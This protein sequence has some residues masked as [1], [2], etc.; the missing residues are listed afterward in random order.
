MRKYTTTALVLG[1]AALVGACKDSTVVNPTD[2]PTAEALTGQPLSR[3]GL[4]TLAT[5][6]LAAD[7]NVYV[8][9]GSTYPIIANIWA[10]EEVRLDAS[11][12]RY[13]NET[14][15]G[16]PDYG[17]F[18]GG[19]GWLGQYTAVR[20]ENTMLQAL[21]NPLPDAFSDA[22]IAA[23]KGFARTWKGIDYYRVVELRDTVGMALQKDDPNDLVPAPLLCKSS[24]LNYVAALLDSANT[25]L[26][27]ASTGT[28]KISAFPWAV[29]SGMKGFGR[30]Y[31]QISNFIKFNRGWKGKVDLYRA[32]N[33]PAPA[34]GTKSA[35]LTASIAELTAALGG[36]APG[37]VSSASFT[38][39]LYHVFG[40]ELLRR[41]APR[42]QP[43]R[44]GQ[45]P[46]RR[47]ALE[48]VRGPLDADGAGDHPQ[49]AVQGN[50]LRLDQPVAADR[51]PA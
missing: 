19:G 43:E 31:S 9:T 45:A 22:E 13:V 41:L 32:L 39:G 25:E 42:A 37:A 21:D 30:D 5:G 27:T 6:I 48:Q 49:A 29:P 7:R 1:A 20:Q 4:A 36:A 33:R 50:G 12:P 38:N 18:A 17:S 3:G 15:R 16:A 14:L 40:A 8:G 51:R 47:H 2:A 23:G 24:A 44:R 28:G 11:E 46:G 34:G 26:T 35:L 10:R